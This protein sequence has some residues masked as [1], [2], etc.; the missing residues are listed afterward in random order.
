MAK[1]T[2]TNSYGNKASFCNYGATIMEFFIVTPDGTTQDIVLGFDNEEDYQSEY[3]KSNNPHFGA[4]VGPVANRIGAAHYTLNGINYN[5]EANLP[6]NHLHGGSGGWSLCEWNLKEVSETA[7]EPFVVFELTRANHELNNGYTGT[8]TATVKYILAAN[9]LIAEIKAQSTEATLINPTQH[10]YFNLNK[11]SELIENHIVKI[12]SN[13]ILEQ[14]EHASPTGKFLTTEG[15]KYQLDGTTDLSAELD[16]NIG[17][18]HT[19]VLSGS[20]DSLQIAAECT[21]TDA[22]F[23]LAVFTT[24]PAVHFYT[25]PYIPALVGKNGVQYGKNSGLCFETQTH[26]DAINHPHFPSVVVAPGKDYF[27]RLEYRILPKL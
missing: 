8:V 24:A 9:N 23:T 25:G 11:N 6:P 14:N 2:L 7:E 15:T 18:D 5:L 10:T 21:T 1:I 17:Y 4:L 3:Y 20:Q 27:Q 13:S 19:F 16:S 26:P 22:Q 12:F